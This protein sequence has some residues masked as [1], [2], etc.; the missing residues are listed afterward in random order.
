[1][2]KQCIIC[3]RPIKTGIKYCYV[4]RS[5]QK[6]KGVRKKKYNINIMVSIL[7]VCIYFYISSFFFEG[8]AKAFFRIFSIL[9]GFPLFVG[10]LA[11]IVSRS[12]KNK[13]VI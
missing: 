9:I 7:V 3:G 4:C 12:R 6:A 8:G 11:E 2:V 5:L 1:M 13:K 10:L